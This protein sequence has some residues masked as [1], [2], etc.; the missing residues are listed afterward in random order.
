MQTG[1]YD[2]LPQPLGLSRSWQVARTMQLAIVPAG[3]KWHV[4]KHIM[5]EQHQNLAVE[6]A[7]A[8]GTTYCHS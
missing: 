4:V 7:L 1:N 8:C 6:E 2:N 5:F 3:G